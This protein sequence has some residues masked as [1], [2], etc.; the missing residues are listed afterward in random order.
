MQTAIEFW[1]NLVGKPWFPPLA[2]LILIGLYVLW[3]RLVQTEDFL[4]RRVKVNPRNAEAHLNLGSFLEEKGNHEEVEEEFLKAIELNPLLRRAHYALFMHRF[5]VRK[6]TQAEETLQRITELFP[7]DV[8]IYS[9]RGMLLSSQDK[10]EEAVIM[11]RLALSISPNSFTTHGLLGL[12]FQRLGRFPDA[13]D[14]FRT[15]IKIEPS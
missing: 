6:T 10:Y 2:F 11:Y 9:F 15:A 5:K 1:Q 3:E 8:V 7:D 13:E 4:R 14:A 12:V